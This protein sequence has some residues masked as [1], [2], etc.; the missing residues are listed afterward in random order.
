[1]DPDKLDYSKIITTV[2]SVTQNISIIPDQHN[3]IVIDTSDNRLGINTINPQHSIDVRDNPD[4]SGIIHGDHIKTSTVMSD[5]TPDIDICYNLGSQTNRWNRIDASYLEVTGINIK[6]AT[7]FSI[8]EGSAD[9]GITFPIN[10]NVN[11]DITA[12]DLIVDG[13]NIRDSSKFIIGGGSGNNN[14]I[15]FPVTTTI[16]GDLIISGDISSQYLTNLIS[17]NRAS[18][19]VSSTSIINQN[20]YYGLYRGQQLLSDYTT[21]DIGIESGGLQQTI[22]VSTQSTGDAGF[23]IGNQLRPSLTLIKNTLYTFDLSDVD[24]ASHPFRIYTDNTRANEYQGAVVDGSFLYL[25]V[26]DS[27]TS[28]YYD[29]SN[30][31]GMGNYITIDVVYRKFNIKFKPEFQ[32]DNVKDISNYNILNLENNF[33]SVL[34]ENN[35][36]FAVDFS[37]ITINESYDKYKTVLSSSVV[38]TNNTINNL[39]FELV[40]FKNGLQHIIYDTSINSNT[41]ATA[42]INR[43]LDNIAYSQYDKLSIGTL[44]YKVSD[45]ENINYQHNQISTELLRDFGYDFSMASYSTVPTSQNTPDPYSGDEDKYVIS[46]AGKYNYRSQKFKSSSPTI[47]NETQILDYQDEFSTIELGI[48]SNPFF[49]VIDDEI[50]FKQTINFG[51][52]ISLNINNI[53]MRIG[54]HNGGN[55]QWSFKIKFQPVLYVDISNNQDYNSDIKIA[56]SSEFFPPY[57]LGSD[58]N[59]GDV[60]I[61]FNKNYD[62]ITI[63]T[64]IK[65][66]T[67]LYLYMYDNTNAYYGVDPYNDIITGKN[68]LYNIFNSP[69]HNDQNLWYLTNHIKSLDYDISVNINYSTSNIYDINLNFNTINLSVGK[70]QEQT[71]EDIEITN[72]LTLQS[73]A[74]FQAK[75]IDFTGIPDVSTGLSPGYLYQDNGFIKIKP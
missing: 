59:P 28:L 10:V 35:Q 13:I 53:I 26:T 25:T 71:F 5:L 1:M 64:R 48:Q 15:E 7:K 37:S 8:G 29:C 18:I 22:V 40:I 52:D 47:K 23:Y 16:S 6:D 60:S 33:T 45:Q 68:R 67:M 36:I 62:N 19:S 66:K 54:G 50:I 4:I 61:R 55:N 39:L 2:N 72:S 38:I 63:G 24:L 70:S 30:H 42:I 34:S 32:V 9:N 74:I 14:G 20:D 3:V 58:N 12:N 49:D 43:T 75:N 65:L 11:G 51:F 31:S 41:E 69:T 46:I 27:V 73:D 56:L 57:G 17:G 21:G 44:M